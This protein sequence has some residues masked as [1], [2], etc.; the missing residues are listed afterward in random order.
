MVLIAMASNLIAMA[1]NLRGTVVDGAVV[2]VDPEVKRLRAGAIEVK[3]GLATGLALFA[4]RQCGS[5]NV[6][7][8]QRHARFQPQM[9]KQRP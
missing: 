6:K 3:H 9:S 4:K 8:N 7:G 5:K 2:V 1:C